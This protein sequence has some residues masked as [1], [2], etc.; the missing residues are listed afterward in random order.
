[1][2]LIYTALNLQKIMN[3]F[4]KFLM[5]FFLAPAFFFIVELILEPLMHKIIINGWHRYRFLKYR[6]LTNVQFLA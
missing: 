5:L 2:I 1:M 3:T 6:A 4:F